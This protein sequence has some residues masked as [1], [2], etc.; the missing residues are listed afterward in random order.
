MKCW[1]SSASLTECTLP[2][3]EVEDLKATITSLGGID[4]LHDLI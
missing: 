1:N 4:N 3:S 2:E